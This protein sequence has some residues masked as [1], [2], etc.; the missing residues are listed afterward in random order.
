M[1][2]VAKISDDS[3]DK[4]KFKIWN[5]VL[6]WVFGNVNVHV[7]YLKSRFLSDIVLSERK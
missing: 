5:P 4:K 2:S 7:G 3:V 1:S 6:L